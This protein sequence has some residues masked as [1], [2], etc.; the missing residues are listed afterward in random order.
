[1]LSG[2]VH[3]KCES[4]VAEGRVRSSARS[5]V[6]QALY[7]SDKLNTRLR[8][9]EQLIYKQQLLAHILMQ[10]VTTH[11]QAS[12]YH[13]GASEGGRCYEAPNLIKFFHASSAPICSLY[14]SAQSRFYSRRNGRLYRY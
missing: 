6:H 2:L 7:I 14:T 9:Y 11:D 10:A 8:S 3:F 4:T 5:K 1:M 12:A 13:D